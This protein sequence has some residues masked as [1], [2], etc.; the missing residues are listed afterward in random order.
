MTE[1]ATE[2]LNINLKSAG[3]RDTDGLVNDTILGDYNNPD[4]VC[5]DDE[6]MVDPLNLR[7]LHAE[8]RKAKV[9]YIGDFLLDKNNIPV[10]VQIRR[11]RLTLVNRE[12]ADYVLGHVQY[13]QGPLI[14][15]INKVVIAGEALMAHVVP[16]DDLE[17]YYI[18]TKADVTI[19]S[20]YIRRAL[21]A[22]Y[23]S[24]NGYDF[25]DPD[26]TQYLRR[27][28]DVDPGQIKHCGEVS[29]PV[30]GEF[31][32]AK[33]S[34]E[35]HTHIRPEEVWEAAQQGGHQMR[36]VMLVLKH[37]RGVSGVT[38]AVVS[39]F[40]LYCL[41][42]RYQV[43][44][45]VA[46]SKRIWAAKDVNALAVV[47][48]DIATPL[49]SMHN[50]E[51]CDLTQLFEL[52][53][54]VNRGIG[55][56]DWN[57]EYN[58]RVKPDVINVDH[59]KVYDEAC[60]LF[61]E[62][63]FHGYKYPKLELKDYISSR[64]EWAPSGSVHSQ[65][66]EDEKYVPKEYRHK[67]KFV[68]LNM[69]DDQYVK[70][71]F[72]RQPEIH[73]WA[74]VKH[75]WAKQRAIYGVDLT[76]TVITNYAMYR[77]E[78]VFKH[79]FPI[80]EEAAA[81]RVHR[82]LKMMLD[83]NESFCY[84]FDDFNAQHSTESMQA[85]LCAY[86]NVFKDQ[87]TV[88]QQAAMDWVIKSIRRVTV[89]N[90]LGG[91]KADYRTV[92]TLLSGWRLT[93]FMN[94]A[95][96]YIY[97]KIAGAFDIPG[98]RDSVHNGDDVLVAIKDVSSATTIHHKMQ[99]INARAQAAKCN[100]FSV[101]EFLRVEH[102]VSKEDG[103]GA[104]YLTRSCATSVH[105]RIE[106]QEPT[107]FTDSIKA[108]ISR[109]EDLVARARHTPN[110]IK[111]LAQH[112]IKRICAVFKQPYETAVLMTQ[113]HHIVGGT[114]SGWDGAVSHLI[115]EKVEY[116]DIV[117]TVK[118]DKINTATIS[119]LTPGINAYAR[120]LE[121]IY[122]GCVEYEQVRGRI[123]SATR[124]QL[125]VTRQ[126]WL[127]VTELI[128]ENKYRFGRALYKMYSRIVNIPH[129]EKA[130]FAGISPIAMLDSR[131]SSIVRGLI[132]DAEDVEYTLRAYL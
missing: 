49:K 107:K 101:G 93:T 58:H 53:C 39:T 81:D 84:D 60:A 76:S 65:Y 14:T 89:H 72:E 78:E 63:T 18:R 113:L 106:S 12:K 112:C 9:S 97:F 105:S 95:L 82:R 54:L 27:E 43:A 44:V 73:A 71:M 128:E 4:I 90:S 70:N 103:L 127:Q 11:N 67:T 28:F 5:G 79:R 3:T 104:Q 126:T 42:A 131:T 125:A 124:R 57:A 16:I 77:C 102:K 68:S 83:G 98:V 25:S 130:R 66:K 86:Y 121:R 50:A 99:A 31:E 74:S 62:G 47:L 29:K 64:W 96:N 8:A 24:V 94:T 119:D 22:M 117:Q 114:A 7:D 123:V 30:E 45:L 34:S 110:T 109:M 55:S 17:C 91:P 59:N 10:W 51:I 15:G 111:I 33:V 116:E 38:E 92:G 132:I 2:Q 80:G 41:M 13:R 48:K 69:M 75:E 115:E 61:R 118:G 52:Q 87:M 23:S 32:R 120:R 46:T 85:V 122:D 40:M 56:I 37:L 88:D 21:S 36:P 1:T 108:T 19:M 26:T 6:E 20:P 100:V 35:H 129:I